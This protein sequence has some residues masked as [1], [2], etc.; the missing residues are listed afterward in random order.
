LLDA[1]EKSLESL[2]VGQDAESIQR[3]WRK[4]ADSR[5]SFSVRNSLQCG[6][7]KR[8]FPFRKGVLILK[9]LISGARFSV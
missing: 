1:Y 5:I 6:S 9:L 7:R 4:F 8:H 2:T 3:L